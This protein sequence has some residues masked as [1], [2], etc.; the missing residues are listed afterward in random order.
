MAEMT[1]SRETTQSLVDRL[2]NQTKAFAAII[3]DL[4]EER[5]IT[6]TQAAKKA[7]NIDGY[8]VPVTDEPRPTVMI[9]PSLTSCIIYTADKENGE[10]WI[11]TAEDL[12]RP[13]KTITEKQFLGLRRVQKEA[14]E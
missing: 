7:I 1:L 8:I 2:V 3:K 9:K 11:P 4:M 14:R 12:T 6:L 13:W 10:E 5:D